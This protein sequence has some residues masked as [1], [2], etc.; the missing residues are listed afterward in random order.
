M[1][2]D[3]REIDEAEILS[4]K[5]ENG[6]WTRDVLAQWGVPWPPPKGWKSDLVKFGIP[7]QPQK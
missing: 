5:T 4:Q 6:G 2:M 3:R 7:Y 1:V